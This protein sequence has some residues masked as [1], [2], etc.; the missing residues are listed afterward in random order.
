[1]FLGNNLPPQTDNLNSLGN[2]GL[3]ISRPS[4]KFFE[5]EMK[6]GCEVY[7]YGTYQIDGDFGQF[8][9]IIT[10]LSVTK[11]QRELYDDDD[12]EIAYYEKFAELIKAGDPELLAVDFDIL[13]L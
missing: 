5:E 1:M 11:E 12:D 4:L 13:I 10:K 7:F 2:A 8:S 9:K 6:G 3:Y